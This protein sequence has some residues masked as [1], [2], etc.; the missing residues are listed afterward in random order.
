MYTRGVIGVYTFMPRVCFYYA[1][2]V[3]LLS[4]VYT[5]II[6]YYVCTLAFAVCIR[7]LNVLCAHGFTWIHV[8]LWCLH[9]LNK[10]I[11][12]FCRHT[13]FMCNNDFYCLPVH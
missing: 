10:H 5:F 9:L 2:C 12:S 11:A 7:L 8:Y 6:C 4:L 3:H 1:S 13:P